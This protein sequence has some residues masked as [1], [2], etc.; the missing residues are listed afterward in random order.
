MRPGFCALI[1]LAAFSSLRWGELAE[2]RR[3]DVDLEAGVV[4]GSRNLAG[5]VGRG[6]IGPPKSAAGGRIV[7]LPTAALEALTAHLAEYVP[8]D[9]DA[10]IFTG[11][12]GSHLRAS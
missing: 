1:V 4:R 8:H 11:A 10:L 12:K 2:L 6:E 9:P 5:M 7:A 3:K